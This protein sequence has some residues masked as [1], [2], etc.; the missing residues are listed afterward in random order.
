MDKKVAVVTGANRGLGLEVC[1]QLLAEGYQ[2]VLTSREAKKG[3]AAAA[4]LGNG[5]RFFPLNTTDGSGIDALSKFLVKEFGRLD[6]L[7]NNAGIYPDDKENPGVA[8]VKLGTLRTAIETNTFGPFMLCQKLAPLMEKNGYGRIVNV[9][10]GMGQLS[11]MAGDSAAYRISKTALNA[12]TKVFAES[13]K[14]KNI[15]VNSVCPGWVRTEMG[16]A[17]APRD[18]QTGAKSIVWAVLIPEDGP[19][20]GFFRDGKPLEW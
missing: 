7:V 9:S 5:V 8:S 14:G 19:T 1:R 4:E 20:G 11:Q 18:L 6:V 12:V 2:V 10:S 3:E 17:Q 16:G 13:Y 15:L